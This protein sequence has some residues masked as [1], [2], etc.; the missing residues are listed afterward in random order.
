[1]NEVDLHRRNTKAFIDADPVTIT[2]YKQE[3]ENTDAGGYKVLPPTPRDPQVFR[4]IPQG[5]IMPKVQTP[6]GTQLTP[7]YVLLGEH[8]CVMERW[9]TFE[10]LGVKFQIVS[11]V[12]PDFRDPVNAYE[13]KADVARL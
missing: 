6:D 1:M 8:N 3:R 10:L 11:P 2:L 7:T 13:R 9:D 5:D 12:R 4:L